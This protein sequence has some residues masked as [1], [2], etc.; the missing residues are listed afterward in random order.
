MTPLEIFHIWR[1]QKDLNLEILP[2]QPVSH[3]FLLHIMSNGTY[4]RIFC[5]QY[6]PQRNVSFWTGEWYIVKCQMMNATGVFFPQ[7]ILKQLCFIEYK[8]MLHICYYLVSHLTSINIQNFKIFCNTNFRHHQKPQLHPQL[9]IQLQLQQ[10]YHPH[11][12]AWAQ[13]F[14]Q[15]PPQ[16]PHQEQQ[17]QQ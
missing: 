4:E 8:I 2:N 10:W 9:N 14:T 11:L 17:K 15:L 1:S 7:M 3:I 6:L 13:V 16:Q 5:L 12:Q